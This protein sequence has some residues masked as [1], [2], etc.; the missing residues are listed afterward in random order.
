MSNSTEAYKRALDLF[1]ESVI[2][3]DYT[4]RQ[5]AS[6]AGCYAELMEIRQHLSLIHI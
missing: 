2:R 1:T 6:Y 5:N 3:P 4:L